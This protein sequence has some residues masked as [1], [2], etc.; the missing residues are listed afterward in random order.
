MKAVSPR[1]CSEPF[2]HVCTDLALQLV[3][4]K[5]NLANQTFKNQKLYRAIFQIILQPVRNLFENLLLQ[6]I[7]SVKCYNLPRKFKQPISDKILFLH[8]L[9]F[10]WSLMHVHACRH[11]RSRQCLPLQ[12]LSIQA[13]SNIDFPK[14]YR[15]FLWKKGKLCYFSRLNCTLLSDFPVIGRLFVL[16]NVFATEILDRDYK[17]EIEIFTSSRILDKKCLVVLEDKIY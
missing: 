9:L 5:I 16:F 17:V 8:S 13:L 12:N 3:K 6:A 10:S 7:M 15:T 2:F 1:E 14:P 11:T 4:S